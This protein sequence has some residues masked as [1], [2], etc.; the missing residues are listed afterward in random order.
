LEINSASAIISNLCKN[1]E[2]I[3]ESR[4]HRLK[5]LQKNCG[6]HVKDKNILNI[7]L[8]IIIK[9]YELY[10]FQVSNLKIMALNISHNNVM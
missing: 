2:N 7:L 4:Q 8:K 10:C 6:K 5:G 1:N 9:Q 3:I